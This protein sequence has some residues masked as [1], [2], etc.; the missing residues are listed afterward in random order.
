MSKPE[1]SGI[2][3]WIQDKSGEVIMGIVTAI[4]SSSLLQ[5]PNAREVS[6]QL[7][8]RAAASAATLSGALA[9][10]AGPLG[11][12]TI[13]PDILNIWRL[14]SQLVA[15]IA[16]LHGKVADLRR[17]EMAWCLFRH[18]STLLARDFV[19]RAGQRALLTQFGNKAFSKV[20]RKVGERVTHK[21]SS[22]LVLRLIP[23]LG[24]AV[25]AGYAY[26]DTREVGL[27]ALELFGQV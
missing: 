16:A 14:Q 25:S 18:A 17:E 10:P 13:L 4:P 8:Q 26:Y 3:G 6:L 1:T 2:E 24:M 7:I 15:D 11:V 19:V 21:L 5:V 20:I 12:I 23:L 22:R 9:L 27:T